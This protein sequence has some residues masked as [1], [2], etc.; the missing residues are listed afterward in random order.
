MTIKQVHAKQRREAKKLSRTTAK[1]TLKNKLNN[2][3]KQ[4]VKAKP[5]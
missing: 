1:R 2:N 3:K 4:F 5:A